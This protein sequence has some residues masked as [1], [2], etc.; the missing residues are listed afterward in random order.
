MKEYL[1]YLKL[2]SDLLDE[3]AW[4]QK[5]EK[6]VQDHFERLKKDTDAGKV[7]LAGRTL[8]NDASQFGIVIFIEGSWDS[9]TKYMEEDP[10]VKEGVMTA[11]LFPYRIALMR[12]H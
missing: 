3:K 6:I 10:A 4:T 2:R 9:A 1:Y 5:E 12:S 7:I 11:T 8:N